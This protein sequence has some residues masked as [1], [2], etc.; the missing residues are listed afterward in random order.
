MGKVITESIFVE[1]LHE[2][3]KELLLRSVLRKMNP[4]ILN[5]SFTFCLF[6][7]YVKNEYQLGAV[8]ESSK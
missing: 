6:L 5:R 4:I 8:V 3:P 7:L 1:I 2:D